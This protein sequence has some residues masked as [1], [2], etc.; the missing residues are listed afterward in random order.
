MSGQE[1]VLRSQ[2]MVEEGGYDVVLVSECCTEEDIAIVDRVFRQSGTSESKSG[3]LIIG[4][5]NLH[6]GSDDDK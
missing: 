4:M 1:A 6:K 3:P 5:G 2:S